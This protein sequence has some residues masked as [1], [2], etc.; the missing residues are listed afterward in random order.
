LHCFGTVLRGYDPVHKVAINPHG[1]A[2]GEGLTQ[3]SLPVLS[4]AWLMLQV[5][6]SAVNPSGWSQPSCEHAMS[7]NVSM[8]QCFFFVFFWG[9]FDC[10]TRGWHPRLR[11]RTRETC[12]AGVIYFCVSGGDDNGARNRACSMSLEQ[13]LIARHSHSGELTLIGGNWA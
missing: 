9:L 7:N 12:R 6:S 1:R 8:F 3:K 5:S 2:L 4:S 13:P 10:A 11:A